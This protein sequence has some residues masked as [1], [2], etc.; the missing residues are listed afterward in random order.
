VLS[1]EPGWELLRIQK[2]KENLFDILR[3][4]FNVAG[5]ETASCPRRPGIA[6]QKLMGR[7]CDAH[8]LV[9]LL[10]PPGL[11]PLHLARP[12]TLEERDSR[13]DSALDRLRRTRRAK[14]LNLPYGPAAEKM[15]VAAEGPWSPDPPPHERP[16]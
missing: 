5:D 11:P 12:D 8:R 4:R 6:M 1:A 7:R 3:D 16:F 15:R 10:H 2:N 14:G 13:A 9:P